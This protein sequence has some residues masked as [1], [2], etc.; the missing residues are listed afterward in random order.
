[1]KY[2]CSRAHE[3]VYIIAD[4]FKQSLRL[5]VLYYNIRILYYYIHFMCGIIA[6][7]YF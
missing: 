4:Y 3:C 6:V 1:M 5:V 7:S 2:V